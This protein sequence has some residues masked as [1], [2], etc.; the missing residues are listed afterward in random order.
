MQPSNDK[1]KSITHLGFL[2]PQIVK[3]KKFKTEYIDLALQLVDSNKKKKILSRMILPK[4]LTK[5]NNEIISYKQK[6]WKSKIYAPPTPYNTTEYI[7]KNQTFSRPRGYTNNEDDF[8]NQVFSLENPDATMIGMESRNDKN[9]VSNFFNKE[10]NLFN[11]ISHFKI[12]NSL[13]DL[14]LNKS[15]SN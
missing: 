3:N 12:E 4:N 1:F 10:T 15:F 11:E 2:S 14:M 6:R 13:F 8:P 9:S 7:C 5:M